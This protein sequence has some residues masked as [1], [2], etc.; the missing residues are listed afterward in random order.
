MSKRTLLLLIWNSSV[1]ILKPNL[2]KKQAF[3]LTIFLEEGQVVFDLGSILR[4]HKTAEP[5]PTR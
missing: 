5:C 2:G 1:L 4:A 3:P